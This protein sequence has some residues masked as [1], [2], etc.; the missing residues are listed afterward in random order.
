MINLRNYILI[1]SVLISIQTFGQTDTLVDGTKYNYIDFYN[2]G[3]IKE[4]GNYK[5]IKNKKLK[6]GYWVVFDIEGK[7]IEKGEYLKNKK[8]GIWT[9]KGLGGQCCWSGEYKN[10]KKH[11]QWTNG[12][13]MI[14]YYRN[15]RRKRTMYVDYKR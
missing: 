8:T 5:I 10:G 4:L 1:C 12:V 15:G 11:G 6:H 2:N 13:N 7:I 9:D 3:S 14:I